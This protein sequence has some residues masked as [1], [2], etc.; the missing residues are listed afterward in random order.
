MGGRFTGEGSIAFS[1]KSTG[2]DGDPLVL[3]TRACLHWSVWVL[4]GPIVFL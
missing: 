4:I 2:R 1:A 3:A